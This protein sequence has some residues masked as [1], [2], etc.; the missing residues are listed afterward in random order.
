MKVTREQ[1]TENRRRIL[2]AASRL[3]RAKGFDTV[4][5]AEVMQNAGLTHGGFYRHFSSKDDLIGQTL[6][7][8][9]TMGSDEPFDLQAYVAHYLSPEHRDNPDNGCPFA[10]FAAYVQRQGPD[11]RTVMS[12]GART[13]VSRMAGDQDKRVGKGPSIIGSWVA[14]VGAMILARAVN[15]PDLSDRILEETRSLVAS[16]LAPPETEETTLTGI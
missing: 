7:H 4:T 2:D 9:L 5:V 8:C 10:A 15:D 1:V 16:T 11:A 14:M 12:D 6:A 3:F 13:L